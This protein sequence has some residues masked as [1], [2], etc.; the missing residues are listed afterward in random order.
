MARK[1][2]HQRDRT[3]IGWFV[4]S[5]GPTIPEEKRLASFLGVVHCDLSEV[6][7]T[8]ERRPIL[9]AQVKGARGWELH[10]GKYKGEEIGDV[11]TEYLEWGLTVCG[12]KRAFQKF[13]DRAADELMR[14]R[15][16][17]E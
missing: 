13:Q 17:G 3:D 15:A 4:S 16:K 1:Q 14:R 12:A 10:F 11:P 2:T 8:A 9:G 7:D 6:K 5:D